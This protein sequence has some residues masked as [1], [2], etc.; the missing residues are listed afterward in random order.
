MN[1]PLMQLLLSSLRLSP[2]APGPL[3]QQL[4]QLQK[5][6]QQ[7][8]LDKLAPG[9]VLL[10]IPPSLARREHGFQGITRTKVQGLFR[11]DPHTRSESTLATQELNLFKD[12]NLSNFELSAS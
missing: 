9:R 4:Q 11:W 6:S 2:S 3:L 12:A 8:L 7:P 1:F 10:Y 5:V